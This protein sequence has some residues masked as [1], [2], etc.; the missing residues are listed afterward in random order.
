L[1]PAGAQGFSVFLEDKFRTLAAMNLELGSTFVSF[2]EVGSPT[3]L[4]EQDSLRR[5]WCDYV[6][7]V[8]LAERRQLSPERAYRAFLLAR[9]GTIEAVNEAYE[10]AWPSILQIPL[11]QAE[12]D[13]LAFSSAQMSHAVRFLTES[14]RQALRFVA[15]R[16]RALWNTLILVTLTI[17]FTLIVN[18]L[19]AYALSRFRLRATQQILI[20]L[21]ATMAFPPEVGMIPSFLLLRDL[22][23]LNTFPALILPGLANGFSIFLLKGFFDSLPQELYEAAE[24]DGAGAGRIFFSISLP[25]SLPILAVIALQAFLAAYGSFMWAFLVCQ[26]PKMWTLMV[27]LYQYQM[28]TPPHAVMAALV[29]ASIPTLI[30]FVTCQKVIL[31]GIIIPTL[32]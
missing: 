21:L 23:L 3:R 10:T 26:E 15:L 20:Y 14:Y 11:P 1:T 24:I 22:H 2:D 27:W 6:M 19:A 17:L 13:Y 18:P 16:G 28:I 5:V 32:K 31:R 4:P 30:V 7:T 12:V 29:L 25:L 9:Y 8:P